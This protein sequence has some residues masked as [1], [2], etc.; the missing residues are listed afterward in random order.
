MARVTDWD[1]QVTAYRYDAASRL[2]ETVLPNGVVSSYDYDAAGRLLEIQHQ[3]ATDLLSSFTYSYDRVGTRLQAREVMRW[4]GQPQPVAALRRALPLAQQAP[5]VGSASGPFDPLMVG[6][7]PFGLLVLIPLM[8]RRRPGPPGGP[9]P[10]VSR[11]P[12]RPRRSRPPRARPR[13]R[14]PRPRPRP[15]SPRRPSPPP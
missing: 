8:R 12:P 1:S 11:P 14:P 3:T 7:A 10:P 15:S 5:P 2:I 9:G 6:M 4:P 13:R